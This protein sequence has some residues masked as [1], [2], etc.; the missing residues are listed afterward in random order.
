MMIKANLTAPSLLKTQPVSRPSSMSVPCVDPSVT[1]A[2]LTLLIG[3]A[4]SPEDRS[5]R[6]HGP[7]NYVNAG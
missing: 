2:K 4:G 6:S 5:K 3:G 1:T 7:P